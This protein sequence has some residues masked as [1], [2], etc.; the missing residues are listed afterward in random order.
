M[1]G[2]C[3]IG[4]TKPKPAKAAFPSARAT[5]VVVEQPTAKSSERECCSDKPA[6]SEKRTCDC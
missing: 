6:Q 3:C 2:S 1:S 5:E 4:S